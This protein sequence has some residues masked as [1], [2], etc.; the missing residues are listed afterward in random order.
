LTNDALL[1]ATALRIGGALVTRNV[2]DFA[3]LRERF[4]EP[5]V[6]ARTW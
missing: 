2:G 6:D 1:L 3:R 5:I 4:D